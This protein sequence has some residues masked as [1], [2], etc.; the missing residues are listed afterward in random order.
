MRKVRPLLYAENTKALGEGNSDN[1]NS[2]SD[3]EDS[4]GDEHVDAGASLAVNE[5]VNRLKIKT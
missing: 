5:P 2:D 3:E 1:S 4:S